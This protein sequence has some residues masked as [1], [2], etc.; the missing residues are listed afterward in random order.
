MR[1]ALFLEDGYTQVVLTP[2]GD[3]DK[4]VLAAIEKAG[5]ELSIK[6]GEFYHCQG[7]W[8][9]Q[10]YWESRVPESLMLIVARP[11]LPPPVE[12]PTSGGPA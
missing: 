7:G 8:L 5:G 4:A 11:E 10:A 12:G 9:R 2:E 1:A 6:R 3:F